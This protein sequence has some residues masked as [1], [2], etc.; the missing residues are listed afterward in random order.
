M[1]QSTLAPYSLRP[2]N[3]TD[4]QAIESVVFDVLAEYGLRPDPGGTDADL[5]DI[6]AFYHASGGCFDVLVDPAGQLVGTVGLMRK[7]PAVCELRKMYLR[8][9]H[10]GR[11]LGRRLMEH[12]IRRAEELGF[13]RMELETA[14]VLREAVRLYESFGFRPYQPSHLAQ[15]CD[16]AYFRQLGE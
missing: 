14:L 16:V 11:G 9:D 7:S 10:R 4:R 2:A 5:L 8:P 1:Q 6:N 12:A 15:R 13:S 3:N